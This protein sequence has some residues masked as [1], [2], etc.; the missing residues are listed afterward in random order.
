MLTICSLLDFFLLK[1]KILKE[2]CITGFKYLI[3][4]L[5][6]VILKYLFIK[7]INNKLYT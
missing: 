3:L 6:S 1:F 7:I 5:I 4:H 2:N